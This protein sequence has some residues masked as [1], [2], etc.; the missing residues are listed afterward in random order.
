MHC[1]ARYLFIAAV[2]VLGTLSIISACGRKGPLY[3]PEQ[4]APKPSP[5]ASDVP[6]P[7]A[8]RPPLRSDRS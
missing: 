3:L 5:A 6:V 4:S 7:A 1:W 2:V 8:D